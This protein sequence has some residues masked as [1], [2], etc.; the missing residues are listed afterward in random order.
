MEETMPILPPGAVRL[1][2]EVFPKIKPS[3]GP[4][5]FAQ[6]LAVAS[7]NVMASGSFGLIDTGKRKLLVTCH[8]VVEDF[9]KLQRKQSNLMLCLALCE[10]REDGNACAAAFV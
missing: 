1:K 7:G 10:H 4:I 6:S 3:V 9:R 2:N 5:F 8:H